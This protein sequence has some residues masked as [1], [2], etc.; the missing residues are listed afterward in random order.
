MTLREEL[1]KKV[2]G[3]VCPVCEK[4]SDT[5]DE[6][7]NAYNQDVNNEEGSTWTACDECDYQN[8]MDI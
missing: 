7:P 1:M 4:V 2:Q 3:M 8:K 5:V 6:R